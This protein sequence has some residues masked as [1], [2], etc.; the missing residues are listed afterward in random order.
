MDTGAFPALCSDAEK[1][2]TWPSATEPKLQEVVA[3]SSSTM[4]PRAPIESG[5]TRGTSPA[6]SVVTV[7]E[8]L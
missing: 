1:V 2:P 5:M 6:A 4:T 7:S 3:R 8:S